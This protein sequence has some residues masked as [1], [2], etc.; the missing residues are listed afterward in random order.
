MSLPSI[1][2]RSPH[3]P[4]ALRFSLNT[5]RAAVNGVCARGTGLIF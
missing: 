5:N 3:I 2:P 1:D 4:F